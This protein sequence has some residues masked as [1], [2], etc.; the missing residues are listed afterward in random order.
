MPLSFFPLH[1]GSDAGILHGVRVIHI[2]PTRRCRQTGGNPVF[3]LAC[4][5]VLLIAMSTAN[6]SAWITELGLLDGARDL[7]SR[8][9]TTLADIPFIFRGR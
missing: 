9:L 2:E 8:A 3:G 5:T 6:V 1:H 4:A 7:L